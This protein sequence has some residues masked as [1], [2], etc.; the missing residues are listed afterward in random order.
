MNILYNT[1]QMAVSPFVETTAPLVAFTLAALVM[2]VAAIAT[3]LFT[4]PNLAHKPAATAERVGATQVRAGP[5]L[6]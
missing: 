1:A 3:I 6:Q 5:T 4:G 2:C